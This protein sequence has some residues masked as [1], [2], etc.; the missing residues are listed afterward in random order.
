MISHTLHQRER[1]DFSRRPAGNSAIDVALILVIATQPYEGWAAP[2]RSKITRSR[3]GAECL[4]KRAARFLEGDRRSSRGKS[5]AG[6]GH[7]VRR[8]RAT[9]GIA[10]QIRSSSS[11]VAVTVLVARQHS[12]HVTALVAAHP[13]LRTQDLPKESSAYDI[14]PSGMMRVS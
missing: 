9:T 4:E 11:W 2:R 7:S 5:S 6:G 12:A 8:A 3:I 13:C 1:H 14:G 10:E